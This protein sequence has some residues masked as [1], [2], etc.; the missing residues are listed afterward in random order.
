LLSAALSISIATAQTEDPNLKDEVGNTVDMEQETQKK[1]DDW[2]AEKA[3]L[4]RRYQ[5][6][7]ANVEYLLD[8]KA[9]EEKR[10]SALQDAIA[11]FERRL[12]ESDQLNASLQDTLDA[13]V[14]RLERWVDR[15]LPFLPDERHTRIASLKDAIA[16][17]DMTGAEKLRRVLEALMIE[18]QYGGTVEVYQGSI[19][20]D[21]EELFVDLLRV[22]R[23]SVFW[24]TP[25]GRRAGEFDRAS[26]Q[27]VE[28]D[29][30]GY[31]R[32]IGMA[33]DMANRIRPVELISLPLGRIVP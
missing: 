22:G 4:T 7:K 13:V 33:M 3:D 10:L 12:A 16:S 26:G 19:T 29:N 1:R 18:A 24:R 21:G 28:F 5:T 27:W 15:D 30:R 8:R 25:N 32:N 2:A 17:P 9:V 23:V 20:L 31:S 6:A 14:V 11:E